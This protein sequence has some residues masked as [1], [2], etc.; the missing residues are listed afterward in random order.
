MR[1]YVNVF[2]IRILYTF[3]NFRISHYIMEEGDGEDNSP[4]RGVEHLNLAEVR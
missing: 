1:M 3:V 4:V 2:F